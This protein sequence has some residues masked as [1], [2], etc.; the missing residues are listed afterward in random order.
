MLRRY[1]PRPALLLLLLVWVSI[2]AYAATLFVLAELGQGQRQFEENVEAIADGVRAKLA[3]NEAVLGG[4]AAFLA[5][6][7]ADDGAA[8]I[9]AAAA[10]A[11]YPHIETIGVARKL[12]AGEAAAFEAAM[13]ASGRADFRLREFADSALRPA[14]GGERG[15]TWPLVFTYP[16]L[17][18]AAAI[19][20]LRLETVD[21]LAPALELAQGSERPVATTVV[22]LAEGGDAYILLRV[23][24]RRLLPRPS[25]A[26]NGFG[27]TLA[28]L[29]V[30]R[31]RALFPGPGAG[32]RAPALRYSA[33]LALPGAPPGLLLRP[34]AAA[35]SAVDSAW[36]PK[37]TR[38]LRLDNPVQPVVMHFEQ[39]LRWHEFLSPRLVAILSLLGAA[40]LLVPGLALRHLG[41]VEREQGAHARS[42]YLATHDVLTGL[43]N[44]FLFVDRFGQAVVGW[45]RNGPAFALLLLDLDHFKA[46]NDRHG[47]EVGDQVLV[48]A[49]RRM[50]RE[51]RSCDT[52][53]RHGGD[54]FI[55]L[56]LNQLGA[57]DARAVG[58]KLRAAIAEPI[59][60]AAGLLRISCSI[61][62]ALC[63]A[64]GQTLE[65]L[66]QAADQAMYTAK[67]HGRNAVAVCVPAGEH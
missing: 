24:E 46:V 34:P 57:E 35:G 49:A 60:T 19:P 64:S 31:T 21:H 16:A 4:L 23:V 43:P 62:I 48:E 38:A 37:F 25:P 41:A 12:P 51:L 18:A 22:S 20:G 61:G 44:R 26:A 52:V 36:L 6:V 53:A 11:A 1:L 13:R 33:L 10:A 42:A 39:Q 59:L 47:H 8:T 50:T 55:I 66:R 63:P 29:L 7:D 28:A 56:A 17:P 15:D 27:G 14:P 67:R 40:L 58:E 3:A 9:Y 2:V 65:S 32:D 30:I 45:Q 54:E 5:A